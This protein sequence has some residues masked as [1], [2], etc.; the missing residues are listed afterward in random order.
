VRELKKVAMKKIRKILKKVL[1]E[2][3]EDFKY[4]LIVGIPTGLL[5]LLLSKCFVGVN[6]F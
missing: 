6:L 2:Y 5:C 1:Q 3:G 4:L